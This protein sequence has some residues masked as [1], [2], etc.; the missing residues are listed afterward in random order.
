MGNNFLSAGEAI[1]GGTSNLSVNGD[2]IASYCAVTGE[3]V[4]G[5]RRQLC[6]NS[7]VELVSSRQNAADEAGS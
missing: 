6:D 3:M 5:S 2:R 4:R 1:A 7:V